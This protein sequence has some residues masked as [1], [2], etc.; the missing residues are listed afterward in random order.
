M[1]VFKCI[2]LIVAMVL[3]LAPTARSADS[4]ADRT[5]WYRDA[6]FGMFIHWGPYSLASVEASWPI[7]ARSRTGTST[8]ADISRLP[9]QFNPTQFDPQAWVRLAKSAGQRYMVFT[10]KHHDGFCMFDSSFTTT[11]S[12]TR[13]LSATSWRSGGV[14]QAEGMPLGFTIRLRT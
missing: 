14:P 5:K 1:K 9:Q 3:L 13:P 11:R 2:L 10:T 4:Q 7:M 6:K 8:E 12:P